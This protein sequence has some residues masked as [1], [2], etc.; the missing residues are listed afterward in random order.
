MVPQLVNR[1]A[2]LFILDKTFI[3]EFNNN[4]A[5]SILKFVNFKF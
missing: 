4:Y 5:Q 3:Q 2:G 1:S